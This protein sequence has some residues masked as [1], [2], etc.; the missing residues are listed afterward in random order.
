VRLEQLKRIEGEGIDITWRSFLLRPVAEERDR[1]EFTAY[2]TR[3]ARPAAMEPEAPFTIPWSDEHEPPSHSLPGAVAGKLVQHHFADRF[4]EFHHRLLRAYFSENRDISD[5]NVLADVARAAGVD[6]RE[7]EPL[8]DDQFKP[9]ARAA[10]DDHN[11]AINAGIQGVPAVVVDG[12]YLISGAVEV[13]H[14]RAALAQVRS[15]RDG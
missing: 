15:E 1:A 5:R 13:D 6:R 4:D 3:W 8:Y 9:L 11:Q 2:T 12:R 14:Y 7:F 10:Y